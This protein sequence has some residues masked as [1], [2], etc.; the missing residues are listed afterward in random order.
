[1]GT[2]GVLL[3]LGLLTPAVAGFC[4]V[5]EAAALAW[6]GGPVHYVHAC[7]ALHAVSLLLLGPGGYSLDAVLYGRRL[8]VFPSDDKR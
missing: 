5:F 6:S 3:W 8:I 7:V 1:M 4:L 2:A